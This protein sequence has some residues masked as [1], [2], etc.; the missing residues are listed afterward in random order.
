MVLAFAGAWALWQAVKRGSP[1]LAV[2]MLPFMAIPVVI[3][4]VQPLIIAGLLWGL[5]RRFGPVIIAVS[6]SLK[7]IP[8]ALTSVYLGRR[9]WTSAIATTALTIL[10][11][12][13]ILAFDLTHYPWT[14]GGFDHHYGLPWP[15][16]GIIALSTAVLLAPTRFR[17]LAA[18]V[19]LVFLSP[20]VQA[21]HLTY[22]LLGL[23]QH[24]EPPWLQP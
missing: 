20:G 5:E 11:V 23:A 10:L 8:F 1:P 24:E 21:Y 18:G 16:T 6:A 9:M 2:F 7:G 17:W 12:S 3:G 13:P 22:L 4:N 15:W 14:D 19:A